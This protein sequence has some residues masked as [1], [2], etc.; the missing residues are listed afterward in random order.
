MKWKAYTVVI[1]E[2][3]ES[4]VGK[5]EKLTEVPINETI[6]SW[7]TALLDAPGNVFEYGLHSYLTFSPLSIELFQK[8]QEYYDFFY[9]FHI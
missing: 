7:N 6:P 2:D 1:E 9:W 8:S 3:E 4:Q 5:K